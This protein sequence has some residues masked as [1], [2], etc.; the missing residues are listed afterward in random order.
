ME[1]YKINDKTVSGDKIMKYIDKILA[2][3]SLGHSQAEVASHFGLDRTFISRLE[4]LGE[5]RKGKKIALV[6]FPI[7]NIAEVKEVAKR[8]GINYTILLK[9]AER[10]DFLAGKTGL[11]I[12]NQLIEIVANI[13]KHDVVILIGSDMRIKLI[14]SLL[15]NEVIGIKIGESPL[16]ED[17]YVDVNELEKILKN[18]N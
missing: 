8:F 7:E 10:W 9:E 14:E 1:F 13:R 5:I 4:T 3:R 2:M 18:L 16:K 6:G 12:F 11:D 17:V 15:D